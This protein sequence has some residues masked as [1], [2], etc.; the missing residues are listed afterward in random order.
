[1]DGRVLVVDDDPVVADGHAR[2]LAGRYEVTTAYG[3]EAALERLG[4]TRFDVVLLDRRMPDL[5]GEAVLDR[6]R[7][8][9]GSPRVAMVT[10]VEPATDI[11]DLPFDDYLV[12][13]VDRDDLLETV[14]ALV[15][16]ATY[17]EQLQEFF[18]LAS[19]IAVLE[20]E[21]DRSALLGDPEYRRL[22]QRFD[23]LRARLN[24]R[25][26][27]LGPDRFAVALGARER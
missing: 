9:D 10:G 15:T 22:Q 5:D 26:D 8:L 1:M 6:I 18:S 16:R 24:D 27:D 21:N 4:E 3:G 2:R 11:V 14:D 7:A 17:D 25:L 23:D 20:T 19:K 12:K 13:P